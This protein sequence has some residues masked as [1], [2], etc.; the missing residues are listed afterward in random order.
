[1]DHHNNIELTIH[2]LIISKSIKFNHKPIYEGTPNEITDLFYITNE[3]SELARFV[4]TLK[5]KIVIKMNIY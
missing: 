5:M 3:R 4:R 2:D 1:M